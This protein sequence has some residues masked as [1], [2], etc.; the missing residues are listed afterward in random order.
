MTKTERWYAVVQELRA[1]SPR[2]RSARW[3]AER[4]EVSRRTMERDLDGLLQ[5]GV[6]L[7][8]E[9]GRNGGWVLPP[10]ASLRTPALDALELTALAVAVSRL[11]STPFAEAGRTALQKIVGSM[12]DAQRDAANRTAAQVGI[13]PAQPL[14]ASVQR[15]LAFALRER[16]VLQLTYADAE[17]QVS[18]RAVEPLGLLG[19][20]NWY[21][22]GW[23]RLR[24]GVRGFRMD[25]IR[26]IEVLAEVAAVR[27]IDLLAQAPAYRLNLLDPA[28][29]LSDLAA[30]SDSTVSQ[31]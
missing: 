2:P 26:A 27:E 6:P 19:G 12:D 16:R 3:L 22:V 10:G 29:L 17:G 31:P 23:C 13:M 30:N 28:G 7:Y 24:E 21:L 14:P 9:A 25:R 5:A 15:A 8:A 1:A 20:H 4:F 11:S 18:V